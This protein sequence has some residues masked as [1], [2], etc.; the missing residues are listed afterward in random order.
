[1]RTASLAGHFPTDGFVAA[2]RHPNQIQLP[3]V[4]VDYLVYSD[5]SADQMFAVLDI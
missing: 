2:L 1:M 5:H 3:S 4:S